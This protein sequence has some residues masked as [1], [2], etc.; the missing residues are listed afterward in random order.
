MAGCVAEPL[1]KAR[2]DGEVAS[3]GYEQIIPVA[4]RGTCPW[5]KPV[6]PGECPEGLLL[7]PPGVKGNHGDGFDLLPG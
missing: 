2:L 5:A 1:V 3:S 4:V 7:L 6:A